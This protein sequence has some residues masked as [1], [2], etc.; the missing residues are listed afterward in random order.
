VKKRHLRAVALI[1]FAVMASMVVVLDRITKTLAENALGGG[2]T[3]DFIP[4]V[5]DFQLVYNTGAAWGMFEG[6]RTLFLVI[7]VLVVGAM[8]AYVAL[9]PRHNVLTILGLG[10][11]AG[12]AVGNAID[13][14]LSGR[15]VDFIHTLFIE[16]P[17]FNVA[18]SAITVG[19]ILFLIA[20]LFGARDEKG[21]RAEKREA[22]AE[23][24][25]ADKGGPTDKGGQQKEP[26]DAPL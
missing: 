24:G 10:M 9:T 14:A 5:L 20:T 8:I 7:A 23:G 4:G 1:V 15:V 25:Q 18:D 22:P 13:R 17:L 11:I 16:F 19:V 12:G 2:N 3:Q 6:A 26:T 21:A